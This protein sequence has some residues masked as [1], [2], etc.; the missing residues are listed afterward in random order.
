M[1]IKNEILNIEIKRNISPIEQIT[2][3]DTPA[4]FDIELYP[5]SDR[6]FLVLGEDTRSFTEALKEAGG[7][8]GRGYQDP[9]PDNV[10]KTTAGWIFGNKRRPEVDALLQDIASGAIQPVQPQARQPRL[11]PQTRQPRQPATRGAPAPTTLR[12]PGQ[13]TPKQLLAPHVQYQEVTYRVVKPTV[14]MKANITVNGSVIP[15]IVSVANPSPT[16][17]VDTVYVN[18]TA[19]QEGQSPED[20]YKLGIVNGQWQVIGYLDD[21]TVTFTQ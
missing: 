5:Y 12:V 15:T 18:P 7:K 1:L 11:A 21:H 9:R 2:M 3:T 19:P 13:A 16:G 17:V 10:G 6:S 14:G 4:A 20:T 8:F